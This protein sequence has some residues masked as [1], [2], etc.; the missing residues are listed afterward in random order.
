MESQICLK[1]DTDVVEK[2]QREVLALQSFKR[3]GSGKTIKTGLGVIE[4]AFP[5]KQFPFGV[6]HEFIS[7]V[8]ENAAATNAFIVGLLGKLMEEGKVC[9][10]VGTKRNIFPPAL[11]VFGINPERIIFIDVQ[12]EKDV[13]WVIE[14]ALKCD[15]LAAVIGELKELSFT[16]SRRLQLVVEQSHVTGFIHRY[17]PK[18][19]NTVACITRW[20][21][22]SI[23]SVLQ[24]GL[25]GVGYPRWNVQL[26]KVRNGMPGAWQIEW[27]NGSFQLI[28][29][30]TISIQ[31]IQKLKTG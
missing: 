8:P 6:I 23:S 25:P 14:E 4:S 26:Q 15:V 27:A 29:T 11:K 12:K 24:D 3:S 7:D 30:N 16:E 31:K 20:K 22:Q 9:V 5:D 18:A 2:L 10:W 28:S 21:I 19:E 1:S 17:S 13:L